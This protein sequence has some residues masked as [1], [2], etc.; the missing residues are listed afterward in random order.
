MV[1]NADK[2]CSILWMIFAVVWVA[3]WLWSKRAKVRAPLSARL[4]YSFP[5]ALGSYL[6][7]ND[8]LPRWVRWRLIPDSPSV[9]VLAVLLT[10][11]GIGLAIWARFYLGGNWSGAVSIK[12]A[13]QLV[14]TGPYAWV[15]HP[16]Y[17][18]ILLA[19]FGTSLLKGKVSGALATALFWLGFWIKSRMEERFMV[20]TFGEE[21]VEYRRETGA[22][23]PK[24]RPQSPPRS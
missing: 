23:I 2:V 3:G 9:Q 24:L 10:A 4:L 20:T 1:M 6:M 21:Y 22:L 19:V 13:H 17:S 12:I 15:R 11:V 14:R 7:V 5:V 18:G 8:N 16:I